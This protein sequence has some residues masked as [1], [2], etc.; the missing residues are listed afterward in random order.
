MG[1]L[2]VC[3]N[4]VHKI[5]STRSFGSQR[6]APLTVPVSKCQIVNLT[7][8]FMA[9]GPWDKAQSPLIH[10]NCLIGLRDLGVVP[11]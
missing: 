2:H 8:T 10:S 6:D 1:S 11:P 9:F 7:S 3:R 5:H 4:S